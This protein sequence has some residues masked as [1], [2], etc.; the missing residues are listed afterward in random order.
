MISHALVIDSIKFFATTILLSLKCSRLSISSIVYS[1]LLLK[2][3]ALLAGIVHGVVVQIITFVSLRKSLFVPLTQSSLKG[4]FGHLVLF[5]LYLRSLIS[6]SGILILYF[7][8]AYFSLLKNKYICQNWVS[9]FYWNLVSLK[10]T[11]NY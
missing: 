4:S 11:F 10:I 6:D 7:L 3:N 1:I 5:I 8:I 2:A 9:Y